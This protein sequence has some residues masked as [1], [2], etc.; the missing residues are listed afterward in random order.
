MNINDAKQKIIHDIESCEKESEKTD[1]VE[2]RFYLRG[3]LNA[4]KDIL[5][6]IGMVE[7]KER[8]MTPKIIGE[9]PYYYGEGINERGIKYVCPRCH[10]IEFACRRDGKPQSYCPDC[11]Q[12]LD[13]GGKE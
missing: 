2:E 11:G 6:E 10:N 4:F 9:D 12:K 13:F 8:P 7:S 3:R 5:E 1:K